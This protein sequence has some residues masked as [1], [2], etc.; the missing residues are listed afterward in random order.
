MTSDRGTRPVEEHVDP[1]DHRGRRRIPQAVRVDDVGAIHLHAQLAQSAGLA[2]DV[3][4]RIG[5]KLRRHTGGDHGFDGSDG[6]VVN[7]DATHRI[8]W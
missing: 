1:L 3:E 6:T 2:M 4:R 7:V 8:L 5:R